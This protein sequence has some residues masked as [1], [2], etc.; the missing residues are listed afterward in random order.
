MHLP[1]TDIT[2]I[3]MPERSLIRI[4]GTITGLN[5]VNL[6]DCPEIAAAYPE[7]LLLGG[8]FSFAAT[9]CKAHVSTA[10]TPSNLSRVFSFGSCRGG[11]ENSDFTD[12][13]GVRSWPAQ[14]CCI[15]AYG[16]SSHVGAS[17]WH[18]V[19]GGWTCGV[20]ADWLFT[21][22]GSGELN[23]F[24]NGKLVG[25]TQ[26]S[27]PLRRVSRKFLVVGGHPFWAQHSWRGC[28]RNVQVWDKV[29]GWPDVMEARS[30]YVVT[31]TAPF[32]TGS[33]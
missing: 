13:I 8:G 28:L 17:G 27:V 2:V 4:D 12:E 1:F 19:E 16:E 15:Y 21:M 26:C 24:K 29:V 32:K 30:R 9:I 31:C 7:G 18:S 14:N 33:W 22:S 3:P 11:P 20:E 10:E 6:A 5:P 25:S 23:T